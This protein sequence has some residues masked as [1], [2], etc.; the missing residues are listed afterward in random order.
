MVEYVALVLGIVGIMMLF[1]EIGFNLKRPGIFE[2]EMLDGMD[3][4]KLFFIL[5]AMAA[6]LYL[7]GLINVIAGENSASTDLRNYVGIS[8]WVYFLVCAVAIFGLAIYLF[9]WVP[10]KAM[11]LQKKRRME[12]ELE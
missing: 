7:V 6:G 4:I 2:N 11:S 5:M 10:K 12:E 8:I 3:F 9:W 1:L